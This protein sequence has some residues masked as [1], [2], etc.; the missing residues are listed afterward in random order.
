MLL[1]NAKKICCDR[2]M[3][4][5]DPAF[6][7]SI[8]EFQGCPTIAVTRGGRIFAGWYSGGKCEPHM[9][10]YNLLIY[11]DDRGRT[12]SEPVV[13]ITSSK[14]KLIH[15][16]DIQLWTAPDGSLHVYWVQ[17]DTE[18]DDGRELIGSE[19]DP[20]AR[21]FGYIFGDRTHS[22]WRM[23]CKD[24]D[25]AV[26]EFGEPVCLD[27]GFLRCKP[28]VLEDGTQ[29][30]FNYDQLTDRYGYSVSSDGG[31]T[32]ERRYGGK[33]VATYFDETMAYRKAD[34]TIRML[35]RCGKGRLAE[36]LSHDNGKTWTD[37]VL[38]DITAPDS[39]FFI[40]RLPSGRVML[41]CSDSPDK[42]CRL[43]VF[44]SED[45]GETWEYKKLIDARNDVSYP[46]A[47][48]HDGVI[49]MVYDR[50]RTGAKEIL[51]ASFTEEDIMDGGRS[52]AVS[53]ISRP[54]MR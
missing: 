32:F 18:P 6:D 39:R 31:T 21:R 12:W 53:V 41:I 20:T 30:N 46:D 48:V 19:G 1:F 15:A 36:S 45:D 49:Y 28:L 38:C 34:G 29:I 27:S 40:R 14:E 37:A 44:L 51:F 22:E 25:A 42:R 24:P 52:I 23:I 16:L 50:E 9:D 11:S 7:T 43:T 54:D 10:N 4:P 3:Y 5:K 33:K 26:I 8:R 47:D 2:L 35:A 13:V 17:N